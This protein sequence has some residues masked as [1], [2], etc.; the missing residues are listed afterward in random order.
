MDFSFERNFNIHK[1]NKFKS[2]LIFFY[3]RE[4][5]IHSFINP[6]IKQVVEKQTEKKQRNSERV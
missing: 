1:M 4:F 6:N 5:F 2:H 3:H